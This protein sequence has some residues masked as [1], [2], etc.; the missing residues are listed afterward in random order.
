L[1]GRTLLGITLLLP[2]LRPTTNALP[3]SHESASKEVS[4][5]VIVHSPV[6]LTLTERRKLKARIREFGWNTAEETV[7][8]LYQD[9]GYFK[10]DVVSIRTPTINANALVFHVSPGKQ[11]HLVRVS[12]RGNTVFSESELAKLIPIE[13]GELFSRTKIAKG[14]NAARKLYE[15]QG[16]INFTPVPTP[17]MNDEAA[18]LAFNIDVDEGQQFRFGELDVQGMEDAHREMLLSAWQ[19]LRGRPYNTEDADKFFNRFFR[20]PLPNIKPENYTTFKIDEH[21]HSVNYSIRFEPSLR[22]R[23]SQNSRLEPIESP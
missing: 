21:N 23:V 7:R 18:T 20:S 15:S 3:Q 16:Y 4:I 8:E 22:Y 12:W 5:D 2:V 13:P 19:G 6:P 1:L 10:A 14:L 11:Y 9:K 17:E